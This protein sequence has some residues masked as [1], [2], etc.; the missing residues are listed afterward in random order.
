MCYVIQR[1]DVKYFQPSV[2]DSFYRNAFYDAQKNGVE[3]HAV[4]FVWNELGEISHINDNI[5]IL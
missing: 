1:E 4:Q 3:M 2:L 5:E